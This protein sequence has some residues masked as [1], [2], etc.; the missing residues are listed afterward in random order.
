[1]A[2]HR[3]GEHR[4]LTY[5]LVGQRYRNQVHVVQTHHV[6]DPHLLV[7]ERMDLV[8][9]PEGEQ[10]R[11]GLGRLPGRARQEHSLPANPLLPPKALEP[12]T[13]LVWSPA[14]PPTTNG[15]VLDKL[16]DLSESQFPYL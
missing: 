10:K 7:V 14:L 8:K 16:P 11:P 2:R 13:N 12:G 9:L 3:P 6:D 15:G 1:M 4:G 5:L